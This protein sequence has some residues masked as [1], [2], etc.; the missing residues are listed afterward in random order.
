MGQQQLLLLVLGVVIVGLA[1]VVG[2]QAF[3]E[4]QS[5]AN[6]DAMVNDGVR[7]ASDIQAWALKPAAFGGADGWTNVTPADVEFNKIG[8][9]TGTNGAGANNYGNLNGEYAI[10]TD[11]SLAPSIT[12]AP[13][14]DV[15]ISGVGKGTGNE[16]CVGVNGTGPE[17]IATAVSIGS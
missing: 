9:S 2:I 8:Y 17:N 5:K 15:F 6:A 11:C 3:S 10:G 12:T 13:A 1:V 7:I 4:N 14:G 16:I